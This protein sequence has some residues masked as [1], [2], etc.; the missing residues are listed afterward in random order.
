MNIDDN[1]V[2]MFFISLC[3]V[4]YAYPGVS[5]DITCEISMKE[6]MPGFTI[7]KLE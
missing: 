1:Y 7:D 2:I 6:Y 5:V 3:S 4:I